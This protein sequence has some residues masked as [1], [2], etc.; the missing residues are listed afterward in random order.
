MG[1][2]ID[3]TGRI[4]GYLTVR[5]LTPKIKGQRSRGWICDCAACGLSCE[6]TALAVRE[7]SQA[8]CGCRPGLT[9]RGFNLARR[10]RTNGEHLVKTL[11]NVADAPDVAFLIEPGGKPV[12][13]ADAESVIEGKE[14]V[15]LADSLFGDN[16]QTWVPA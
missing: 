10:L 5:G 7:A 6:L 2:R 13:R 8:S 11:Q 16:A 4:I 15:P 9:L 1:A 3:F 14:V 12:L